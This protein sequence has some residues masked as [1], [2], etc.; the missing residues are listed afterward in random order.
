MRGG[1]KLTPNGRKS[2]NQKRFRFLQY[3]P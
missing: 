1:L 3:L 2:K